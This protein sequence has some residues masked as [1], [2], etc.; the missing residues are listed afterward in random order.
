VALRVLNVGIDTSNATGK[1]VLTIIGSIAA[2]E[3]EMVLEG[4]R[5]GIAAA[6]ARGAYRAPC[7]DRRVSGRR[8]APARPWGE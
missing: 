1:L 2:F 5:E 8:A 4:Q 3:R 6:K 7:E